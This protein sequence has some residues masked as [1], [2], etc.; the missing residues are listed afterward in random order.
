MYG[1]SYNS[2]EVNEVIYGIVV[3]VSKLIG[4]YIRVSLIVY[5]IKVMYAG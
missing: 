1:Y 3:I 5:V 2:I 4:G